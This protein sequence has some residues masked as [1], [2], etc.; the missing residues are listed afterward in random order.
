LIGT[1]EGYS[2]SD[3][4]RMSVGVSEGLAGFVMYVADCVKR[5]KF[6]AHLLGHG[7]MQGVFT[8]NQWLCK[9]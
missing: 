5:L 7:G 2:I 8:Y 1:C 6:P 3:S 9:F 4:L